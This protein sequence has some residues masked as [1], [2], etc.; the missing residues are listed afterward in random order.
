MPPILPPEWAPQA[1]TLLVWPRAGGDWGDR[2]APARD[3]IARIAT[4]LA[5]RQ[6]VILAANDAECRDSIEARDELTAANVTIVDLPN[7][8]IWARDTGP[9]TVFTGNGRRQFLDFRFNGWGGRHPAG[10]DDALAANLY[11]TG[12]L[13]D[14]ELVR[15]DWV[16]EGGSIESDG[17]G[18]LLTTEHCLLHGRRNPSLDRETLETRLRE[19]LGVEHILWL[20]E[21][22]LEG[23]DTD[24]HI[25]TLARFASPDHIVYQACDNPGDSQHAPLAAMA[26]ELARMRTIDGKPYRLTPLPLPK[27]QHDETGRRL[28]AGYANFLLA[29]GVILAPAYDDPADEEA[30]ATLTKCF[31]DRQLIPIDC[32]TLI[33]QNGALH[34]AAM[35]IPLPRK[36]TKC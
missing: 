27:P 4:A 16:L 15:H 14:G 2:L 17:A 21:G 31:P 6:T 1:A 26:E 22:G 13:G 23:D 36:S 7:N 34:C 18:T 5:P 24:G 10:K 20:R 19:T 8:D 28:P 25:D 30:H 9:I 12:L 11:R 3:A 35:Q 33:R 32:R 29:N